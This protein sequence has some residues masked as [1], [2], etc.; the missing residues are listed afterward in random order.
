MIEYIRWPAR[1]LDVSLIN[2]Y[3]LS[4]EADCFAGVVRNVDERNADACLRHCDFIKQAGSGFHINCREWFIKQYHGRIGSQSTRQRNPLLFAT[5]HVLRITVYNVLNL[6]QRQHSSG[7]LP[8]KSCCLVLNS[9]AHVLS[10][11]EVREQS[12]IL[13][14]VAYAPLLDRDVDTCTRVEKR[15]VADFNAALVGF[16]DSGDRA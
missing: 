7:S 6:E 16:D 4:A 11:R 5:G 15:A 10:S 12:V 14:D 8:P 3:N 13:E 2:D 1:C 9:V